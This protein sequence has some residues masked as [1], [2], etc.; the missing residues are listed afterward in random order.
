MSSIIRF[1]NVG[2]L[3][4]ELLDGE[5]E[6]YVFVSLTDRP[7]Q[8][9]S[10]C[11]LRMRQCG[12][13]LDASMVFSSYR[14]EEPD[15]SITEH[16]GVEYQPGSLRDDF[17]FGGL[18]MLNV[19][20]VIGA[21][22]EMSDEASNLPDGG[23]YALRLS[24]GIAHM[25]A[26]VPES[27]YT[28]PR[29]DMRLS[30]EKQHD[31][32]NPRN[33]SYQQAMEKVFIE[34]LRRINAL[35][36]TKAQV[37]F[38][39]GDYPVAA[40][41][42]IPVRNR[43]ATIADAVNSAL[44]QNLLFDFNVIVVDNGS[45]D[46]TSEILDKLAS[47]NSRLIVLRPTVGEHLGIGGC[48]NKAVMSE[49]CGRFAV[50]LDSDDV[51]SGPDTLTK[52]LDCFYA[53]NCAAVVGSYTMTDFDMNVLPPGVISHDE[54]TDE[55]G[56]DNALRLNG[57]GA[58]RAFFTG[59]L[60][61]YLLPNVS[62]GE[63]YAVLLRLSREYRIGRIFQPIY[64]CRRWK[65]N[66]DANLSIEKTNEYNFYKDFLRSCELLARMEA[67]RCDMLPE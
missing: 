67:N 43:C 54:W 32:V 9:D 59:V 28:M 57:F 22:G 50:Q 53:N 41:V 26:F 16:P 60:R 46:G 13:Y 65:G 1:R 44:G 61:Q 10:N 7:L 64:N 17:D 51:Y 56:A 47:E 27:L 8:L 42:I 37:D 39:Q 14:L 3:Q 38:N 12:D 11:K 33:R 31:Y 20:D 23:W 5:L 2:Q 45:T 6:K 25:I 48:W 52:I 35:T 55:Y 40:S 58:P 21:I 24:L 63:D 29:V 62:Y 49:H 18:V 19:A 4:K 15:G 30:G 34:H 36:G 66:S